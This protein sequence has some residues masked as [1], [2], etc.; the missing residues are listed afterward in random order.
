MDF[1]V[2]IGYT[3]TSE[4]GKRE[5]ERKMMIIHG[6]I[7]RASLMGERGSLRFVFE[8][9]DPLAARHERENLQ[10]R[11]FEEIVILA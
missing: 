10:K 6:E 9:C 5:R 1:H 3:A 4:R 7:D 8:K 2:G 11:K